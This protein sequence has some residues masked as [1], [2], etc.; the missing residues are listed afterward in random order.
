MK[1]VASILAIATALSGTAVVAQE[2]ANQIKARQGQMWTLAIN[3][4]ILGS[5]AKGEMEYD[6]AKAQAAARSLH[7]V[8]M[9]DVATLYPQGS[10]NISLDSGTRANPSIWDDNAD[11]LAKAEALA[12]AARGAAMTA[13]D[14]QEALGPI[15]GQL[16]G[17]CKA[18]HQAHRGP[19]I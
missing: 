4:G 17:A 18:C 9:V 6:V 11:F 19:K 5:M 14:G 3:L 7:G 15:L 2:H 10:D 16:G 1:K 13:G 8:T 12:E